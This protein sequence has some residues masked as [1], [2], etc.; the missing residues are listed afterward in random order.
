MPRNCTDIRPER[1]EENGQISNP[2]FH[3]KRSG[4]FFMRSQAV[5]SAMRVLERSVVVF[6][7]ND[8]PLCRINIERVIVLLVDR[9]ASKPG[10]TGEHKEC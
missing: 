7:Q 10:V 2:R 3:K 6:S 5:T 9:R 4:G 8:L 1:Q